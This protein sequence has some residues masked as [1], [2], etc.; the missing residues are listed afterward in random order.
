MTTVRV[1]HAQNDPE[2]SD[3]NAQS[4]HFSTDLDKRDV[5]RVTEFCSITTGHGVSLLTKDATGGEQYLSISAYTFRQIVASFERSQAA[6]IADGFAWADA[7]AAAQD[8]DEPAT[9]EDIYGC[10]PWDDEHIGKHPA[11]R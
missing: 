1:Y 8:D 7:K 11:S 2:N 5:E 4:P 6:A 9:L 3:W 10:D